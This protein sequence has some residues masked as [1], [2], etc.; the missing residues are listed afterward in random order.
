MNLYAYLG[1]ENYLVVV[2]LLVTLIKCI[3]IFL[4]S[5]LD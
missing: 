3:I 1:N 4:A 5:I 2:M